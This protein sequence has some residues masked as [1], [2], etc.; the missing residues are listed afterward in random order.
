[1]YNSIMARCNNVEGE[2]LATFPVSYKSGLVSQQTQD[3]S[4]KIE[5]P[6]S[7]I[8]GIAE[9]E[10]QER[11]TIHNHFSTM[12][13]HLGQPQPTIKSEL[14]ISEFAKVAIGRELLITDRAGRI[15]HTHGYEF[16]EHPGIVTQFGVDLGKGSIPITFRMASQ[17]VYGW[18]PACYMLFD[19]KEGSNTVSCTSTANRFSPSGSRIDSSWFA[20]I[21]YNASTGEYATRSS[22]G[23][24]GF[25]VIIFEFDAD[26][27]TEHANIYYSG[28]VTQSSVDSVGDFEVVFSDGDDYAGVTEGASPFIMIYNTWQNCQPCQKKFVFGASKTDELGSGDA[29]HRWV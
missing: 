6:I 24:S 18:A 8:E 25:P 23:C 29:P 27:Y 13:R 22:C 17:F 21:N 1:M 11:I 28:V 26:S 5:A 15:P 2:Y 7:Q 3:K 19:T 16:D 14:L 4:L 9:I 20:C 10:G 12:L